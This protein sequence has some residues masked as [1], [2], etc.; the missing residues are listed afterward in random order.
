[1]DALLFAKKKVSDV[2]GGIKR[3]DVDKLFLYMYS[4]APR[5]PAP[6]A[7]DSTPLVS[8][9]Y[10]KVTSILIDRFVTQTS[11]VVLRM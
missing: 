10:G 5:P 11:I 1:M 2:G 9:E 6:D 8:I 4:T 7:L 3:S